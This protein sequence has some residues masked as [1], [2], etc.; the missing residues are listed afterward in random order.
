M[1][2]DERGVAPSQWPDPN[3]VSILPQP[4]RELGAVNRK[5]RLRRQ[6][7]RPGRKDGASE[8][9]SRKA[10]VEPSN[11]PSERAKAEERLPQQPGRNQSRAKRGKPHDRRDH[12]TRDTQKRTADT[13]E[14][15]KRGHNGHNL[16]GSL[17]LYAALDLG[18]N[19]CRLL[20]AA[21]QAPGRFRVVDAFSRIVRLGEGLASTGRLSEEAMDRSI[22]ALHA[23]AAKLKQRKIR[24][25]RLIATEACRR[26]ANG[27]AFLNRVQEETGLRLD[28]VDRETEARLAVAGCSSLIDRDSKGVVLFDIGGGSSE[29]A[30]LDLRKRRKHDYSKAMIS[31]TSL[32]VGV[33]T[34]SERHGGGK[35][36]TRSVFEGMVS[37]VEEMLADY[38]GRDALAEA[39]TEGDIHLLGTSG[40]VTTLAGIHL[41]LPRY[42]RRKVDGV[43]MG[44]RQVE[45]IVNR[46]VDMSFEERM[47]NPCIGKD[48]ADLV[49]AGCAI[50]AAIQKL[51]PYPRLRVADR[52]LRE[53]LLMDMMNADNAWRNRRHGQRRNRRR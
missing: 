9:T 6:T 25:L 24:S 30:L 22:E 38:E 52:G 26:A 39:A 41:E 8:A 53:G 14:S 17:P 1:S 37:E 18:T 40:T 4:V 12:E 29:L 11:L 31:W 49:L 46:L 23:C 5:D 44:S 2:D 42:D 32:P 45:R 20:I 27:S 13:G 48:R 19:N 47:Q 3:G 10:Q 36:V 34:L 21:P 15:S 35:K 28:I 51:W 16:S 50:L 43:W 7:R 33:V